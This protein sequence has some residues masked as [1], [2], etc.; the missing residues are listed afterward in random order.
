VRF[1]LRQ[2]AATTGTVRLGRPL[3]TKKLDAILPSRRKHS[4]VYTPREPYVLLAR[5]LLETEE[6]YAA[7]EG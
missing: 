4:T 3:S 2:P 6:I 1:V 7:F 5:V